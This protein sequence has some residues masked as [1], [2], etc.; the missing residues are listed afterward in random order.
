MR[1]AAFNS[2]EVSMLNTILS[3]TFPPTE[4]RTSTSISVLPSETLHDPLAEHAAQA[5]VFVVFTVAIA[6]E[7]SAVIMPSSV[8]NNTASPGQ[9]GTKTAQG[10]KKFVTLHIDFK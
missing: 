3:P 9:S 4:L 1:K 6:L 10:K 8:A 2:D 7:F 5:P